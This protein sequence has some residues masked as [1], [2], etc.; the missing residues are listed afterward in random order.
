MSI[1]CRRGFRLAS[2]LQ[3]WRAVLR[4]KFLSEGASAVSVASAKTRTSAFS[5]QYIPQHFFRW[6]RSFAA[7]QRSRRVLA[8]HSDNHHGGLDNVNSSKKAGNSTEYAL[9]R[10]KRDRPD[11]ASKVIAGEL[12]THRAA[13]MA[14][15]YAAYPRSSQTRRPHCLAS[16]RRVFAQAR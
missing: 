16:P 10:L 13:V 2:A 7:R 11:L 5:R 12:S 3:P 6:I 1:C 8:E 15:E 9:R 4:C 14:E